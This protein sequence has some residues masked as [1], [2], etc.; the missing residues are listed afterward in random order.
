LPRTFQVLAKTVKFEIKLP[1][2]WGKALT[3]W[4]N[5]IYSICQLKRR[6]RVCRVP[7]LESTVG[8][9]QCRG[10]VYPRL[11]LDSPSVMARLALAS[12]SNLGDCHASLAM[13]PPFMSLRGTIVPKQSPP[14][15]LCEARFIGPKQSQRLP[16]FARN[17]KKRWG[18]EEPCLS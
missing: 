5:V 13:T 9:R 12:R 3:G 2:N 1:E 15:C 7:G 16:R 17:D 10:G 18:S 14:S 6:R 4:G 8:I 11:I